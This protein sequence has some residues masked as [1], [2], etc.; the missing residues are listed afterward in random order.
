MQVDPT[1]DIP[2]IVYHVLNSQGFAFEWL[3]CYLVK[4][5]S[6]TCNCNAGY[7]GEHCETGR[8]YEMFLFYK[9]NQLPTFNISILYYAEINEC[10]DVTCNNGSCV[11]QVNSYTCDCNDGYTGEHC[12]TGRFYA[13]S[14]F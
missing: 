4:V 14:F 6:Y 13:M 3:R 1:L 10:V 11:D 5:Y 2:G 9:E 12:E 7:T 8:L